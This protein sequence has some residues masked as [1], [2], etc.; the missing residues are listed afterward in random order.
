MFALC[1]KEYIEDLSWKPLNW[2]VDMAWIG[3]VLRIVP[4]V[5]SLMKVVEELFDDIPE[6]GAE[7]KKLVLEGVKAVIG[8]I[9]G[10]VLTPELWG[11]IE[12]AVSLIIDAAAVFLFPHEG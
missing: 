3:V 12:K 4:F 10:F 11:K 6:S 9:G 5:I 2:R 7:K 8:A 1:V